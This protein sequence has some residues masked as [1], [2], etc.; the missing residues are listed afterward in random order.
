MKKSFSIYWFLLLL[1]IVSSIPKDLIA[2]RKTPKVVF[3]IADGIPADL[4]E[5]AN[6]PNEKQKYNIYMIN[7]IIFS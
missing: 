3:V 1:I 5:K 4:L 6:K 2:Q 7:T